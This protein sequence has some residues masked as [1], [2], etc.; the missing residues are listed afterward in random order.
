MNAPLTLGFL[1][2][3]GGPSHEPCAEDTHKWNSCHHISDLIYRRPELITGP[4]RDNHVLPVPAG[5]SPQLDGAV[6]P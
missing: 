3:D 1:S 4:V 6:L 2:V 5:Q